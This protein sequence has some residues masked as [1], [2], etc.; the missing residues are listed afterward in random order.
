MNSRDSLCPRQAE[1]TRIPDIGSIA[2]FILEL[3]FFF[4][5][6][7]HSCECIPLHV[8]L[9]CLLLPTYPPVVFCRSS[10]LSN[11]YQEPPYL[12]LDYFVIFIFNDFH[13]I[14]V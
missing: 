3:K 2:V 13:A 8:G 5:L 14:S 12:S 6:F 7:F 9:C 1:G 4:L 11:L 10:Q